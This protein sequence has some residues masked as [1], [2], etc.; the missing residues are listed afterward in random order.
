MKKL[1]AKKSAEQKSLG[2]MLI[3]HHN[4]D[5]LFDW[6]KSGFLSNFEGKRNADKI[7]WVELKIEEIES[8]II[9]EKNDLNRSGYLLGY[10]E[11]MEGKD[12]N[13]AENRIS[14][15]YTNQDYSNGVADAKT[16]KYLQDE[17]LDLLTKL[18]KSGSQSKVRL[19][20]KGSGE[21]LLLSKKQV[22]VLV[23]FLRD[24]KIISP[25]ATNSLIGRCFEEMCG[26][27]VGQMGDFIKSFD[28]DLVRNNERDF[29]K[30]RSALQKL[31]EKMEKEIQNLKPRNSSK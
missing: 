10:T 1:K 16:R 4:S 19:P 9:A 26:F 3:L 25:D 28:K 21:D 2:E 18:P 30:I 27:E 5:S 24:S 6:F 31:A 20:V 22:G 7:E 17:L 15:V 29:E 23:H 12:T 13:A 14:F 11:Y 8:R